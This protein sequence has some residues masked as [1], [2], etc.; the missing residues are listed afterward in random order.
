[1]TGNGD[2]GSALRA[3]LPIGLAI[4]ASTG[5]PKALL[6]LLADLALPPAAYVFL[7]QHIHPTFVGI[8]LRRL[9]DVSRLPVEEAA[10]DA[11]IQPGRL[12][13]APGGRHLRVRR[14]EKGGFRAGLT[15]EPPRHGVRPS[16]DVLF[17]SLAE[18]F[19][20][21]AVGVVLTGMGRDGLEGA[22]AIKARGGRILAESESSCVVYGMPKALVEAGL[23]DRQVPIQDMA[24]AIGEAI[25][26]ARIAPASSRR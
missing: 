26:A 9:G 3:R 7:V 14:V 24:R 8:L 25:Q 21:R 5:G 1:V 20:D 22:R 18:A 11:A 4:G 23:A 15:D 13:V 10:D 17:A 16:L 19:G 2:R 6:T 12:Y